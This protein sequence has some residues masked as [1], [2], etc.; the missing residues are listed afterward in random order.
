M[1]SLTKWK[2]KDVLESGSMAGSFFEN[3]VIVEIIIKVT[4]IVVN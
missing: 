1:S 3:F 2:D 4:I